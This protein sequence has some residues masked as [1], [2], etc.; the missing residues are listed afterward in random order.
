[1][2]TL[3]DI[4]SAA[5]SFKR[6]LADAAMNPGDSLQQMLGYASD[7]NR[8][9]RDLQSQAD[10]EIKQGGFANQG[11]ATQELNQ[12]YMESSM[13]PAIT[14]WHGSPHIFERFDLGKIGTGEGNQSYGRGLYMAQ[15]RPTAEEYR[16]ALSVPDVVLKSGKKYFHNY[17]V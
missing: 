12:A 9:I 10:A 4:Y 16:R 14:V 5:D 6:R 3:A 13:V 15:A 2:P 17:P 1:M 11:P 7:R 8:N